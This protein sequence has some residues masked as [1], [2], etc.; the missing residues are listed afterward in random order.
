[1]I[2]DRLEKAL[3]FIGSAILTN[4][5]VTAAQ[6]GTTKIPINPDISDPNLRALNLEDWE[7]FRIFYAACLQA[8]NDDQSWPP[9]QLGLDGILGA[10]A[11]PSKLGGF[12]QALL[13]VLAGTL[14]GPGASALTKSITG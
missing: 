8:L 5:A 3:I 9:P 7:E 2:L 14:S 10:L 1:M 4:A 12:V 11:D 6:Y 13:P